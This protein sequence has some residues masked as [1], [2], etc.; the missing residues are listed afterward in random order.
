MLADAIGDSFSALPEVRRQADLKI[1]SWPEATPLI[2][3]TERAVLRFDL[4]YSFSPI[5]ESSTY[6]IG[7]PVTT[8]IFSQLEFSGVYDPGVGEQQLA[9]GLALCCSNRCAIGIANPQESRRRRVRR[10]VQSEGEDHAMSD[11]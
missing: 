10:R 7:D 8:L 5:I 6:C 4:S 11:A 1:G 2:N 9:P 3:Y